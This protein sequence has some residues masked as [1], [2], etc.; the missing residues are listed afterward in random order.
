MERVRLSDGAEL[1]TWRTGTVTG[2]P[3]VVLLHGGPGLWD[4]LEPVAAMIDTLAPIF[5]Y[6]QRGCGR[7]TP[8]DDQS[9]ATSLADLEQLRQAWQAP[10]LILIGHS[11][12]ATLALAYAAEFPDRVAAV[13]YLAGL[14]TGDWRTPYRAERERRQRQYADRLARLTAQQRSRD[15]EIE[16]RRLRWV[17]DYADP[18]RGLELAR[19]MAES[20]NKINF[21]ANREVRFDDADLVGWAGAV[22]CPVTFLHGDRD[23]R[24]VANV[25][26]LAGLVRRSR[27]RIIADAGH[28]PWLERPAETAELLHEVII[29]AG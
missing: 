8:S 28:L 22:R 19:P 6:D 20:E 3:P 1:A 26:E 9:M 27:K 2:R 4:Y 15:E 5:R 10:E 16:W 12:G 21:Q 24:P 25:V 14:G 23:P 7:S 11:F 13:G 18:D 17:H 29:E